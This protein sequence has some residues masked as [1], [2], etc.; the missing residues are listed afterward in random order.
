M[1]KTKLTLEQAVKACLGQGKQIDNLSMFFS[2]MAG[3]GYDMEDTT[4][5]LTSLVRQGKAR[6]A[7]TDPMKLTVVLSD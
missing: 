4:A 5:A 2:C 7:A 6:I 1:G 3:K